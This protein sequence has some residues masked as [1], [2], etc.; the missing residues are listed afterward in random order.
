MNI[1]SKK[2]IIA[3]NKEVGASGGFSNE[4]SFD[5]ALDLAKNKKNWLYELSYLVRSL[6]VDHA[7]Q[8][9]NKRTC[10]LVMAYYLE[11]NGKEFDRQA[12]L[13]SILKISKKNISDPVAIAR[14]IYHALRERT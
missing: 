7:F 13:G 5:F 8:D 4:S 10:L 1:I 14:L 2:D 6:L 11:Q 9:G 12:L 3:F